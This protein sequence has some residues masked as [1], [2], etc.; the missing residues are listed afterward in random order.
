M[1]DAQAKAWA[2][3][4]DRFVVEVPSAATT[5]SIADHARVDWASI[6]GRAAPL[7]VEIG[8]GIGDSLVPM[9]KNRPEAD[10]VA[11]EVF[12]PAVAQT[13]S[14]LVRHGVNNVR[15]VIADGVQGLDLLM[16][17]GSISELWTFFADP[18]HKSRH[19]KRRLVSQRLATLA[20][21]RLVAGGRWR[22]ATDWEDYAL[23]MREVLDRHPAFE[24]EGGGWAP[25]FEDRPVTKF[26][27]RGIEA[28]RRIYDLAYRSVP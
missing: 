21:D 18:W 3:Y 19:H 23:W 13:M 24:N 9:A 4:R 14:R 25:R 8:S 1:N 2:S 7:Y 12:E 16:A 5:T 20:A 28:G 10:F 6:F 27:L 11:F 17:P 22:L 26:E 15:I